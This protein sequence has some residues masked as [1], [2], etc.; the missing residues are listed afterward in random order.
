[1]KRT[2]V[3]IDHIKALVLEYAD[4][5]FHMKT[6]E[7]ELD[8]RVTQEFSRKFYHGVAHELEKADRILVVGPGMAKEEFKNHCESHHHNVDKAIV[9]VKSMKDH[10]TY[11]ELKKETQIFFNHDLAWIGP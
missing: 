7:P 5:E 1:M 3:W 10:P 8:G 2:V 9:E 11:E 6:I 4:G